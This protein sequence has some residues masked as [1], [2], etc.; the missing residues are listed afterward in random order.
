MLT[1]ATAANLERKAHWADHVQ[2]HEG[3]P[4]PSWIDLSV[5]D[6]CNRSFGH[7]NACV[8]CPRADPQ[9]YPNQALHMP[10][11]L[12]RK[13]ADELHGLNYEGAVVLCGF[14]EPLLHPEIV[15]LVAAF[16]RHKLHLEI[17]TN[18]DRLKPHVIEALSAAGTSFFTVSMYDGS[19]QVET[20]TK[21]FEEAECKDFILRDRWHGPELDYGLKLTNRAGTVKVGNQPLAEGDAECFYPSYSLAIDWNGDALLCVQDWHKRVKFGNAALQSLLEI[22]NSTAIH[23]R[24]MRLIKGR[25]IESP[26]RDCNA[27]GTL[28]GSE[29][30]EAWQAA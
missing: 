4:L 11:S 3:K 14:G 1:T 24:R 19:H 28:H 30:A 26:C 22:W 21:A 13:M 6:L 7:P 18:G 17:V 2:L 10:L 12:A 8:F 25:R 20:L 27:C 16:G 9:V 29:H 23:K 5:T 15:D